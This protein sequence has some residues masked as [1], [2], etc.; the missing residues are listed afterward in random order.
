MPSMGEV[1]A[2]IWINGSG[3]IQSHQPGACRPRRREILERIAREKEVGCA[4]L[5]TESR[6]SQPTL[7][8]H[9]KELFTAGLIK[10]RREAKFCFY[11]LERRVWAA[12]L[13][14]MRRRIPAGRRS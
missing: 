12:Y 6:V 11:R 10:P 1:S 14:E 2:T 9:L 7:S 4:T 3:A 8:H 13:A 5:T